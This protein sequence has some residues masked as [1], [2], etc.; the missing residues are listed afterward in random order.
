[1]SYKYSR[2]YIS[3]TFKKKKSKHQ[4]GI[5]MEKRALDHEAGRN[6]QPRRLSSKKHQ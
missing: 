2:I 1:L 5:H 3:I 4:T 6:K